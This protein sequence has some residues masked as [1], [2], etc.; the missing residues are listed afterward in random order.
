[1][2]GGFDVRLDGWDV[3]YGAEMQADF[4]ATPEPDEALDLHVEHAA[5]GWAPITPVAPGEPRALVFIDGVRRLEARLL[6]RSGEVTCYG[7]FGSYGVGAVIAEP[8]RH[9]SFADATFGRHLI[10]GSGPLP[11]SPVPLRFGGPEATGRPAATTLDYLPI[12]TPD[13]EPD[14][15]LKA[16]QAAMRRAEAGLAGF[17][18]PTPDSRLP[19]LDSRLPNGDSRLPNLDSRL[20]ALVVCDGPLQEFATSPPDGRRPTAEGR[21]AD[22]VGLI[23][24]VFKLYLPLT[25]RGV[26]GRLATGQRTPV[27]RIGAADDRARYTWFL[28]LGA[29]G[30]AESELTGLV[31]L[32][33]SAAVGVE[34]ACLLAD[35]TATRLP[36]FAPSRARDPRAPQNLLPIGALEQHL[37]HQLGDPR[38]IRRKIAELLNAERRTP[39]AERTS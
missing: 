20:P 2:F 35:E 22:V 14:G 6:V 15:P 29:P 8:G 19:N 9:A 7:A 34:R 38:L 5:D 25:H 33:V 32:E 28:R 13:V 1:M 23:K 36:A 3:D 31:R 39:N 27:F 4:G 24:R 11:E 16:L 21:H 12:S 26:L 37:R 18:L 10:Y 30:P 17:R